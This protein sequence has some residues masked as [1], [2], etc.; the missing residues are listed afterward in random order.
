ML[1]THLQYFLFLGG[2]DK[3]NTKKNPKEISDNEWKNVLSPDEYHVTRES[4]TEPKFSGEYDKFFKPG[5]YTCKCCGIDLFLSENKF[6]SGCGWPAFDKSVGEDLN[7]IRLEDTSYGRIRTEV[8]CKNCNAHL[9]HVFDDGP[10]NTTGE[11]YCI[12]SVSINFES[13]ESE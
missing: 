2:L 5:K 10:K 1:F 4:G 7:I 13:K 3:L 9:G 12:N 11:R 6:D 8:R